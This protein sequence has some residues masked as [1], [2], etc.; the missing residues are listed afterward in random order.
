M[1]LQKAMSYNPRG[2]FLVETAQMV[3]GLLLVLFLWAH[4]LF[5]ASIWLGQGSFNALAGFMDRYGLLPLTIVFLVLVFGT[6]VGAV[7]RRM[8][9]QYA[10]QRVVWKHAKL[11]HHGDTWSWVFQS[12]TGSAIIVLAVVHIAIVSFAG[13]NVH[14]SSLRVAN[15][16]FLVFYIV[17][18]LL[19]EYHAS[20]GLYRILV[21]WGFVNRYSM[22][23]V[24]NVVSV[25]F[26][27]VGGVSL[28]I[29]YSLGA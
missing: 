12:I 9:R 6:H 5:V 27:V 7:L 2:D 10:E 17:L 4:M 14:L 23:R 16:G 13:I 28:W 3:S 26:I 29:L 21:K 11:I 1:Q 22:K 15:P 18:L 19:S 20:V 24:L 25:L 8:P